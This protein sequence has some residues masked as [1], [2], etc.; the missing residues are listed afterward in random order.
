VTGHSIEQIIKGTRHLLLDFGGQS[1]RSSLESAPTLL[2][3]SSATLSPRRVSPCPD[4]IITA[5]RTG[6]TVTIVSNNSGA[7]IAA[8][9]ADHRL[10]SYIRAIVA[11]D[12][13][14]PDRMKPDPVIGYANKPDRARALADVQAA[15]VTA[16]LAEITAALRT[17]PYAPLPN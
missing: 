4:R 3:R 7:A 17:M 1:A 16:D 6:R 9:L 15:A 2:P 10:T 5:A 11:R 13:H 14:D 8:Y 12:D